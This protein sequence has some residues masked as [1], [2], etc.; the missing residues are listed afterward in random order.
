MLEELGKYQRF[1]QRYVVQLIEAVVEEYGW[2]SETPRLMSQLI[3]TTI[4]IQDV[5]TFDEG[6]GIPTIVVPGFGVTNATTLFFR[7]ILEE[8]GHIM[9][10]WDVPINHGF[11]QCDIDSTVRQVKRL[12]DEYG[13]TV[14]LVGQSLGGCYIRS[15][16]NS[17]PDHI[18]NLITLGAPINGIEKIEPAT[19]EKYDK[20]VGFTDACFIHH[21][22]FIDTF[23]ENNPGVPTTSI[24]SES[25]GV[26]HWS[27]S[28][29]VEDATSE[30]VRVNAGHFSMGFNL[31]TL[32]ILANRLSQ[33]K[34]TWEKWTKQQT[35]RDT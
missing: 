24:F 27:L 30:N 9:F 4:N 7:K 5:K 10:P 28:E 35:S 1:L 33:E 16:A 19:R 29:I 32:R 31:E 14:N 23:I 6:N 34:K 20:I 17:M 22:E 13:T 8:R 12:T 18:N 25:D 26:V 3:E 15:I 2:L 21:G 11:S